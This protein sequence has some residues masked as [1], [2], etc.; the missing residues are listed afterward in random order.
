MATTSL[1]ITG[2]W[3]G[4]YVDENNSREGNPADPNDH[5]FPIWTRFSQTGTQIEGRTRDEVTSFG[6][7]YKRMV[8]HYG[9]SWGEEERGS[10]RELMETF[11]EIMMESTLPAHA[12]LTGRI[13]GDQV[14]FT[15]R[16]IGVGETVMDMSDGRRITIGSSKNHAVGYEGTLNAEGDVLEGTWAIPNPGLFGRMKKPNNCGTFKLFRRQG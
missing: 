7:S 8:E 13:M 12:T 11:P 10:A 3:V 4:Y 1:D 5:V 16:Y 14:T 2:E 6:L 9:K 15:K